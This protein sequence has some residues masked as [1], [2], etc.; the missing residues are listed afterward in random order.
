ML[1]PVINRIKRSLS[2]TSIRGAV[3]HVLIT[4]SGILG[5]AA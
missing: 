5:E 3:V 2:I 4:Y 1:P